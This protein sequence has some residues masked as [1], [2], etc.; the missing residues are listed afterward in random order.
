MQPEI[1]LHTFY[2]F[3]LFFAQQTVNERRKINDIQTTLRNSLNVLFYKKKFL[4]R[5]FPSFAVLMQFDVILIKRIYLD[6]E[7]RLIKSQ[8][9]S[10]GIWAF[11][12]HLV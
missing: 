8:L 4:I 5:F 10:G 11:R 1:T 12:D 7:E 9:Y 6:W 2:S 3:T